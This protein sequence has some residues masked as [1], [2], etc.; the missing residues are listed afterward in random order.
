VPVSYPLPGTPFYEAVRTQV[1]AKRNW[2]HTDDLDILFHGT[3]TADFY[4]MLRDIFHDEVDT[5]NGGATLFAEWTV[6]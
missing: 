6:P 1:G 2:E 3:Y 5:Y 4:R